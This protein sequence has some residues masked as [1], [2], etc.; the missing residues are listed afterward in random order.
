MV[1][2]LSITFK[3]S[4]DIQRILDRPLA[5]TMNDPN[6]RF[7]SSFKPCGLPNLQR[8]LSVRLR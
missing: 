3:S 2:V 1:N 4:Q 7:L 5:E 6:P 8:L